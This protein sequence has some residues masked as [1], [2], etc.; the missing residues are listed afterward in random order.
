MVEFE[1]DGEKKCLKLRD[2]LQD[3]VDESLHEF[4]RT[5]VFT[6]TRNFVQR[7]KSFRK[8]I[9]MGKNSPMC[10]VN[11]SDKLE[12]QGRGAGHI[13]G[14]AWCDLSRISEVLDIQSNIC[15]T[16]AEEGFLTDSEEDD[17]VIDDNNTNNLNPESD[18][19]I[20]FKKLRRND[21]LLQQVLV[22]SEA[23]MGNAIS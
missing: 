5:N 17:D 18:L 4:I 11:F 6:A 15:D 1:K 20:A 7:L 23:A 12:F 22:S 10:I 13:H 9:M 3:E 19:E 14:A 21:K 8:E 16:D 2:F